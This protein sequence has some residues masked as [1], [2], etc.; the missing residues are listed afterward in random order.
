MSVPHARMQDLSKR[1]KGENNKQYAMHA[2]FVGN[3]TTLDRSGQ[4]NEAFAYKLS[5]NDLRAGKRKRPARRLPQA[6][7]SELHP[8]AE[9][10][11][12][13]QVGPQVS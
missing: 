3:P 12:A 10:G 8:E 11:I 4:R 7:R 9:V 13:S 5:D 1:L 6:G 2:G